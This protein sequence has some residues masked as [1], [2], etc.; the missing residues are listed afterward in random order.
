VIQWLNRNALWLISVA[1]M[2]LSN[3]GDG[4]YVRGWQVSGVIGFVLGYGLNLAV[5]AVQEILAFE[6]TRHWMDTTEGKAR[7]RK[8]ALSLALLAGQFALIYFA[9]V[10]AY[11]QYSLLKPDEP[12]L[13]RW[14]MAAFAPAALAL[15]GVAQALRARQQGERRQSKP[16]PQRQPYECNTCGYVAKSQPALNGH[17]RKHSGNG[18]RVREEAG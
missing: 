17:Q 2:I 13:Y 10:F 7:T 18:Q 12:N 16:Q 9:V 5:D 15:L 14:S 1:I 3:G 4:R 11:R 8:R 6:F